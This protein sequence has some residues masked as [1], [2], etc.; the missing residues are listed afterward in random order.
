MTMMDI[1]ELMRELLEDEGLEVAT[2]EEEGLLTDNEG[3]V[4]RTEDGNEFQITI[5]QSRWGE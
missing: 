4:L 2:Y 1:M 5:I 3:L